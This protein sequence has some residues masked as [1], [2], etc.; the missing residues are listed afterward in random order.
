MISP[1]YFRI[2]LN[3]FQRTALYDAPE[4]THNNVLSQKGLATNNKRGFKLSLLQSKGCH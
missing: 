1:I 3:P 4:T 2:K